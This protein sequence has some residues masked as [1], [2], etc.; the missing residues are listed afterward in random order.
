[1]S[2][3]TVPPRLFCLGVAAVLTLFACSSM[4]KH[5]TPETTPPSIL[6]PTALTGMTDGRGRF[7]E[8]FDAVQKARGKS[9]PD[10]RPD[11][12]QDDLWRLAGE[13]P[14][15][16][17]PVDLAPSTAGLRVVL[18]PGLLAECVSDK[19]TLFENSRPNL[20]VQGYRTGYI[21]TR[22][23]QGSGRNAAVIRAAIERMPGQDKIILVCHSKGT[24][25]SLE[26]LVAFPEL[27]KRV[28]AVVSVA[29]AVNGSPLADVFPESLAAMVEKMAMDNC[30]K[31]EG[32]EAMASL[33]PAVRLRWL[34]DHPLPKNVRYYSLA[35]FA[36]PQNMSAVLKPFFRTLGQTKPLNDGLV[37]ASDAIVPGST[38][39]GYPNADH[40]AVAMPFGPKS[41]MIT[42][43]LITRNHYP[44]A[45]LLEAAARYVEEDLRSH[46]ALG[47]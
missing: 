35:A 38:L 28:V 14:A 6:L 27:T 4:P 18:V 1:M 13:P 42:S 43:L 44:R 29:G 9:L 26:A 2:F 3:R 21:Q 40:L 10:A 15:T 19:S 22:G 34:A 45:V 12:G 39:L 30:P 47:K 5:V 11:D 24:V 36:R 31:G 25:D 23:R 33:R 37:V 46:G 41:P 20:E 32:V 17:K 7:R 8:I 16:G